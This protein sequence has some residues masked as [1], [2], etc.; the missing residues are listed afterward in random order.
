MVKLKKQVAINKISHFFENTQ[1]VVFFHCTNQKYF[2]EKVRKSLSVKKAD[3]PKKDVEN[4]LTVKQKN[5]EFSLNEKGINKNDIIIKLIKN[6]YAKK[7]LIRKTFSKSLS[8][9][10]PKTLDSRQ[11][12]DFFKNE[13]LKKEASPFCTPFKKEEIGAYNEKERNNS[14]RKSDIFSIANQ[15]FMSLSLFYGNNLLIGFKNI[16]TLHKTLSIKEFIDDENINLL[17][18][19]YENSIINHYQV[20]RLAQI[21][22]DKQ[23]Y[24]RLNNR[25]QE[26]S[27][28]LV[29]HLKKPLCFD[30]LLQPHQKIIALLKLLSSNKK[31]MEGRSF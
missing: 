30:Y 21:C 9:F 1:L 26:K 17:G 23:V 10:S 6:N 22:G 18:G 5:Q 11:N 27:L 7:V 16:K 14:N 15:R 2:Y 28:A 31:T 8:T 3:F 20:L 12:K 13:G 4:F 25:L 29:S 19:I 24:Q